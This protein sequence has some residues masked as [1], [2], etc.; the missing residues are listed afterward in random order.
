[1][2][3]LGPN[4]VC[5]CVPGN[6]LTMLKP[7][8]VFDLA[9]LLSA[10]VRGRHFIPVSH[11]C[12]MKHAQIL[13]RINFVDI[14]GLIRRQSGISVTAFGL[15]GSNPVVHFCGR[16]A[17]RPTCRRFALVRRLLNPLGFAAGRLAVFQG[18]PSRTGG[19]EAPLSES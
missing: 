1:M 11:R 9:Q 7:P 19:S 16:G 5:T 13:R 2:E 17:T 8:H 18:G 3:T 15:T 4:L 12:R 10:I 6:H 14:P